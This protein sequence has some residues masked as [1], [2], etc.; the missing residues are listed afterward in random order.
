MTEQ[1]FTLN[2]IKEFLKEY[3]LNWTGQI[4]DGETIKARTARIEDFN[5]HKPQTMLFYSSTEILFDKDLIIDN[6]ELIIHIEPLSNNETVN[7]DHY[8]NNKWIKFLLEKYKKSYAIPFYKW[9]INQLIKIKL[10][11][12]QNFKTLE[13]EEQHRIN[14]EIDYYENLSYLAMRYMSYN[15]INAINEKAIETLNNL[16]TQE[17]VTT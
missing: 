7:A 5:N 17:H 4:L 9:I 16:Q 6:F 12:K 3:A 2:D 13:K 10:G 11:L 1:Y 8:L 14:K 15:E